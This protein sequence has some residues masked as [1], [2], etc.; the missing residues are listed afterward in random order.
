MRYTHLLS[1]FIFLM[2]Y[3]FIICFFFEIKVEASEKKD[4]K[5]IALKLRCMTCQNQSI[6]DSDT[7]FSKDIKKII[8]EKLQQNKS[9][10]EIINFLIQRYGEYIAFEPQFNKRNIFLWY[11]PFIILALSLIF[12]IF[13]IK[14]N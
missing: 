8:Q 6:Y 3:T 2:L 4:L 7:D 10:E 11:F 12:L 5:R 9:D 14:K 13:R 1:N